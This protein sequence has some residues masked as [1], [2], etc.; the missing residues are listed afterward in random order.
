MVAATPPP[1]TVT[2]V[3][4]AFRARTAIPLVRVSSPDGVPLVRA[5]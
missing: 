2:G 5:A 1:Y 4:T 3:Q